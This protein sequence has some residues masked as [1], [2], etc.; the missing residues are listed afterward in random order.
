MSRLCNDEFGEAV[1]AAGALHDAAERAGDDGMGIESEYLMGIGCF[2]GSHFDSA[3][4]HFERAVARFA[5]N[6][7]RD[8]VIRFG[9]DPQVV[10]LSRLGNTLRFLGDLDGARRARDGAVALANEHPHSFSR[11]IVLVFAALLALDLEEHDRVREF[12][13]AL[14]Q[15]EQFARPNTIK[16]GAIAGY[17]GVLDGHSR[18]GFA[19]IHRAIEVCGPWNPAPGFRAALMRLLVGAHHAAGDARGGLD[20][21]DGALALGGTRIWEPDLRVLRA[22]FLARLHRPAAEV[23][24]ELDRGLAVA[25]MHGAAGQIAL[26]DQRRER[27]PHDR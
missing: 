26:V 13:V 18:D 19:R 7:R 11:G 25:R 15:E 12:G 27:R 14:A 6:N 23:D 20:A 9:H 5:R 4:E 24:T 2:W 8:H 21:V 17:V 3:C 22:D 16:S 1:A 10:C